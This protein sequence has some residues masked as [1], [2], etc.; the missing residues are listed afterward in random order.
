MVPLSVMGCPVIN[1]F[2]SAE[3]LSKQFDSPEAD[4]RQSLGRGM[5]VRNQLLEKEGKRSRNEQK[6]KA[7]CNVGSTKPRP[8]WG[9]WVTV[10]SHRGPGSCRNGWVLPALLSDVTRW[11]LPRKCTPLG[12][13][14][15]QLLSERSVR[16]PLFTARQPDLPERRIQET[17]LL[18]FQ[19]LPFAPLRSTF[20]VCF[21]GGSVKIG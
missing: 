9:L 12:E 16:W 19:S 20:H 2:L 15:L 6:E 17:H 13:A 11:H 7:D 8:A 21:K 3:M 1:S 5:L 18:V 10:A 4:V 14:G